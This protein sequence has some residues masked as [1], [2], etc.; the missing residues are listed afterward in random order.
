MR[1]IRFVPTNQRRPD[2]HAATFFGVLMAL[3]LGLSRADA[4]FPLPIY[5]PFPQSYTNSTDESTAVPQG[6]TVYP[7]KRINAGAPTAVW[8]IGGASGGGSPLV[9]GGP[10]ALSYLNLATNP[11]SSLG[12]YLRTNNTTATRS[13]GILYTTTSSGSVY[14]SFL[15]VAE[16]PPSELDALGSKRLFAKL[17]NATTG[18]GSGSMAGVWSTSSNTLAISKS[19]NSSPSADTGVALSPGVHLV[20]LRYT[21]NADVDD[22]EVALWVDPTALGVSEGSVPPPTLTTTSGTD[23]AS[24]SSFY[25]YHIGSE[26]VASI[27]IDEIRI[28]TSWADATPTGTICNPAIV[29][30]SPTN[31]TITE[32]LS[33][34]LVVVPGGTSPTIQWQLSTDNG[35]TWN[36]VG[37]SNQTYTTPV[38][39]TTDSG[40]QYRAV[41]SVLCNSSS[42]TSAPAVLTVTAATSTPTGVVVDDTFADGSRI[43]LPYAV[44]N[45]I[46]LATAGLDAS[47]GALVGTPQ[48]GSAV[49]LGFFTDDQTAPPG[50]P[51]HLDVGKQVKATIHFSADSIVASGGNSIR[52]GLFDYADGGTRPVADGSGVANS[53]TGVRGYMLVLNF[54]TTFNDDTPL[55]LYARN[56][57]SAA[58]LMGTTANYQSIGAGPTGATLNGSPA[59]TSGVTNVL[60][61]TVAR[62]GFSTAQLTLSV[63]AGSSNW[64][65]TVT[66]ST[67][68]YPRFDAFGIRMNSLATTANSFTFPEFKVEVSNASVPVNPFNITEVQL[69]SP[70]SLKL[71]WDSVN[72]KTYQVLSTPALNP[73]AWTTNAT[74]QATAA[75]TSYTNSPISGM[76]QFYRVVALP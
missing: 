40:R 66:D 52:M 41:V 8:S 10:A 76:H 62:T 68:A 18:N 35:S 3:L 28:G 56:N 74:V 9:V 55:E 37:A 58:D 50:L 64:T 65:H 32:G 34:N 26:V 27:M 22:D 71:T 70:T 39:A 30:S 72:G 69:L 73:V 33:A 38:L 51:V 25:V 4:Q 60:E 20:V 11:V 47:S 49:W 6:G 5:E 57:L 21:F 2:A 67:Y 43:N 44:D 36:N 42:V 12:L 53:G 31:Q 15:M 59:F 23:V 75:S 45:S 17:D 46:W 14:C 29:V 63:T 48:T 7:A 13:R 16:Q 1:P 61:L 19:S 24:L 54:G